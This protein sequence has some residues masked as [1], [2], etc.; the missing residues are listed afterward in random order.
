[1]STV[2]LGEYLKT[3]TPRD[4]DS[5]AKMWRMFSSLLCEYDRYWP[6]YVHY[7]RNKVWHT[8]PDSIFIG[9][10]TGPSDC[11]WIVPQT[12]KRL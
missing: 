6:H 8:P 2:G 9:K 12:W 11:E 5:R 7:S 4:L 10:L 3:L 1:M